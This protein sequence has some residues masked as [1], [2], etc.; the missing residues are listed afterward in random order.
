MSKYP[1]GIPDDSVDTTV[2]VMPTPI[3]SIPNIA[4]GFTTTTIT[5][6]STLYTTVT[7]KNPICNSWVTVTVAPGTYWTCPGCGNTMT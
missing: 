6:G 4:G 1:P 7:C 3:I 2:P 5:T